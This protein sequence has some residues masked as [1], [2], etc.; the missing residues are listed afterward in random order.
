MDLRITL[1]T[2]DGRWRRVKGR[3]GKRRRR[4]NKFKTLAV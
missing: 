4:E 1:R 3:R 2:R